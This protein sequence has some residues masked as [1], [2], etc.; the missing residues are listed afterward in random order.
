LAWALTAEETMRAR[1]DADA[2]ESLYLAEY[3]RI[4]AIGMRTGLD[5]DEAEDVAQEAFS[6]FHRIHPA[7]AP[8]AAAWLRRAAVHLALNAIRA[9][10]RRA[11][12]EDRDA[13]SGEPLVR[14]SSSEADPPARLESIERSAAVRAAMAG[15][16]ARHAAVLALRYSGM[17]YTEVG[18]A[19]GIPVNQVGSVLRRAESAFKKEFHHASR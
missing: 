15:L 4:H 2:F 18:A 8:F 5:A 11:A 10:R 9:R 7:D 19:L 3:P 12:R 13:R 1:T 6:Q 14:A 16:S 17:S